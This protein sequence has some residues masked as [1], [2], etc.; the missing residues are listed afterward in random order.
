M[1]TSATS[2]L[3]QTINVAVG[4]L[5]RWFDTMQGPRG[6]TGPIADWA[7]QGFTWTG[8]A[9]DWRYE[10]IINGYITLWRR[11]GNGHWLAKAQW[12]AD[13]LLAGQRP[14][15]HFGFGPAKSDSYM[16]AAPHGATCAA[17]LLE[18]GGALRE[19]G[20][21]AWLPYVAAAELT[22]HG[23]LIGELWDAQ[24]QMFCQAPD[25]H[26]FVPHQNASICEALFR[27]A[28]LRRIDEPVELYALPTLRMILRQQ[29]RGAGTRLD[30]AIP[31]HVDGVQQPLTFLPICTARCI[32]ALLKGYDLTGDEHFFE[33]AWRAFAFLQRWRNDDGSFPAA[34]YTNGRSNQ[35]PHWIAACGDILRAAAELAARG[36]SSNVEPTLDW[37]LR[38]QDQSG[39]IQTAIGLGVGA[40]QW[41]PR[42][43]DVR[44]LR[45][46]P[47]WVDKAFRALA[48]RATA[49]HP[50]SHA[51][52][53]EQRCTFR[54]H[55]YTLY[56]DATV[57]EIRRGRET[58]Y[59]WRK[60]DDWPTIC[61]PEFMVA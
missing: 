6:Y 26:G 13:D 24:R 15:G 10:G 59:H 23:A 14:S 12:A 35:Y 57:V 4:V 27:L 18:L 5:D 40:Q 33:G 17:A 58:R 37:L 48:D 39:G 38:G 3:Q 46:V 25:E 9:L 30:G 28:D 53:S 21:E 20:S 31:Y 8:T 32:P 41:R 50:S 52:Q 60:S 51:L 22:I 55:T 19:G 54:G 56:E 11:T 42:L 44:D 36:L 1:I 7:R 61:A 34:V 16:A 45:R 29:L 49:V 43:P 47:G 2:P